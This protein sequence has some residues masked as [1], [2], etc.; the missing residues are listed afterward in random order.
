MQY[1]SNATVLEMLGDSPIPLPLRYSLNPTVSGPLSTLGFRTCGPSA[2]LEAILGT[3]S[4]V[5]GALRKCSPNAVH[6][7]GD[8]PTV[9]RAD[10]CRRSALGWP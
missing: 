3:C 8:G 5:P 6:D 4:D 9:Q 1:F 7:S 2:L 10:A